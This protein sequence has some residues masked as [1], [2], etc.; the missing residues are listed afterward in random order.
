[1]LRRFRA[2]LEDQEKLKRHADDRG[3]IFFSTPFDEETVDFLDN[4]GVPAFKIASSDITHVPLLRHVAS[5]GKPVFLSTGMSFLSE[6]ADAIW[7]LKSAGAKEILLL[8]CVS[9]YPHP[10]M[11]ESARTSDSSRAF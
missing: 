7:N 5:K 6:V 3:I 9:A 1:M 4:L 10:Q 11:L 2:E 8:H